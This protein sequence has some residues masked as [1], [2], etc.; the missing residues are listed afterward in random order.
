MRGGR[1]AQV[2]DQAEPA[3]RYHAVAGD[4]HPDAAA[5]RKRAIDRSARRRL[6]RVAVAVAVTSLTETE[7]DDGVDDMPRYLDEPP[8]SPQARYAAG[9]RLRHRLPR[10]AHAECA[11]ATRDPRR[12][13][14]TLTRANRGRIAALLPEKFRRMRASPFAFF[15]GAAALMAADLAAMP[16]T[17]LR[18]QLCGDA[19]VRNLGA[20][21]APDGALV[22]DINDFDE[23]MPGP[24]EW[25]VKRFATSLVL[26]GGECGEGESTCEQSVRLFVASY[27][28][29]LRG[30]ATMPFARLARYLITRRRG[31]TLLA[32]IFRDA[33]RVTAA[34]NAAKLTIERRN[35]RRFHDK[36]PNLRHVD[37]GTA[38]RVV[39][40]LTAYRA[41]LNA[42]RRR[43]FARYR[44]ADVAFKLVGTGSVGTRDYIVLL[45][46]NGAG[47]PLFLQ[48]KQELASCYA[49]YVPASARI[50]HQGRRVAEGQQM[51]QTLSDPFLGYTRFGGHDYLVRQ[52]ADHKAALDPMA[53]KRQTLFEYAR[54]CGEA[55]AKGH[56]R[57]TDGAMLAG[58]VGKSSRLDK[59]IAAFAMAYAARTKADYR[60]FIRSKQGR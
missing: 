44:P 13:L 60:L 43:T 8:A 21:A 15:R 4:R 16:R 18:V 10:E 20:Y 12:R 42:S 19:H 2:V 39:D 5:D 25:D 41:T 23:T 9:K 58:Y 57:T 36:P 30:F 38:A 27:R 59:A 53:L 47:D 49:P 35:R 17:G 51:M 37:A 52:L 48:V 56:A 6:G 24:W 46:G 3:K 32:D 11:L 29:N 22:F 55:L 7:R 26:A 31:E 40:A 33:E 45:F 1:T 54:L 34:R 28:A 50:D 14:Q